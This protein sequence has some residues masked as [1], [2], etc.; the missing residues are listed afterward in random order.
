M[1]LAI[2]AIGLYAASP[3]LSSKPYLYALTIVVLFI[4]GVGGFR[5]GSGG[6][7]SLVSLIKDVRNLLS[8]TS[9]FNKANSELSAAAQSVVTSS[10]RLTDL[11]R[12]DEDLLEGILFRTKQ[13]E[14]TIQQRDSELRLAQLHQSVEGLHQQLEKRSHQ[15]VDRLDRIENTL[16]LDVVRRNIDLTEQIPVQAK[17]VTVVCCDIRHFTELSDILH[18]HPSLVADFLSDYLKAAAK[19]IFH[20]GGVLYRFTGDGVMALFG[21]LE[22][23]GGDTQRHAIN[24]V[25]ASLQ[26]REKFDELMK[27]WRKKWVVEAPRNIH[28]G[29]GCGIHSGEFLVGTIGT[30]TLHQFTALGSHVNLAQRIESRASHRQI[31]ISATTAALTGDRFD[32]RKVDTFRD[33]KDLPGEFD[34]YEVVGLKALPDIRR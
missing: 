14:A 25:E 20:H 16:S 23:N 3:S 13:L 22:T 28:I 18:A 26:L 12:R 24:A 30:E 4:V 29:L 31:L 17:R 11:F 10:R 2:L 5:I 9:A 27:M 15:V 1:L 33:V 8:E 32:I 21:A 7:Y 6:Y 34:I 19:A